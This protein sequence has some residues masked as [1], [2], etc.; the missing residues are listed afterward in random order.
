MQQTNYQLFD[1]LDF[2]TEL[3]EG[4]RLWRACPPSRIEERNGDIF[5]WIPFQK[6]HN[7]NEI[8]PDASAPKKE[9]VLRIKAMGD[10]ILRISL[11]LGGSVMEDS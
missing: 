10:K 3:N 7:S 6:Q 8:T 11:A 4:D 2:S 5:V 1:F 9:Y